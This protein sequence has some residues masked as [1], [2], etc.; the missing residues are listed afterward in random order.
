MEDQFENIENYATNFD[1]IEDNKMYFMKEELTQVHYLSHLKIEFEN[2]FTSIAKNGG[3]IAF[4][5]KPKIFIM[6]NLNPIKYYI[7]QF[8]I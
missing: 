3:L 6:D 2:C 5:L 8:E 4:C 7:I 1:K